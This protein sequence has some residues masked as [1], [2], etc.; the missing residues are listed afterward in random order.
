MWLICFHRR[1][2]SRFSFTRCPFHAVVSGQR[3]AQSLRHRDSCLFCGPSGTQASGRSPSHRSCDASGASWYTAVSGRC[4]RGAVG[5]SGGIP[6]R[7]TYSLPADDSTDSTVVWFDCSYHLDRVTHKF[8]SLAPK[9]D[10]RHDESPCQHRSNTLE[11]AL[12]CFR[13]TTTQISRATGVWQLSAQLEAL[14]AACRR[15]STI[16]N[17]SGAQDAR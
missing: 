7:R 13:F 9:H 12:P 11:E 15:D 4:A 14:N 10:G 16:C 2:R 1:D 8:L 17:N 3:E 6:T 5:F